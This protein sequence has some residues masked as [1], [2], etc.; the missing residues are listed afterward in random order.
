MTSY[1]E[2]KK[3][4]EKVRR[5]SE[6][7]FRM[8]ISHLMD[9]GI[10]HFTYENIERTCVEI[11]QEDDSKSFMTNE[12]KCDLVRM[13]GELAK[14]DHIHLLAY[15]S[16]EMYYGLDEMYLSYQRLI[17]LAKNCIEWVFADADGCDTEFALQ[18]IREIGFEDE[19]IECL[20]FD[21]LFNSEEK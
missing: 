14:V 20:G 12:F 15:I 16:R 7:M 13:T 17:K 2:S 8:A 6:P 11:M 4:I 9:C 10:K 19:D 1:V 21:Y 5:T 3:K 18:Q